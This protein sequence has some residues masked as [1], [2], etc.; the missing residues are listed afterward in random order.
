MP[1]SYEVTTVILGRRRATK[2][3][4]VDPSGIDGQAKSQLA[5]HPE[6]QPSGPDAAADL[7]ADGDS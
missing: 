2:P 3:M 5:A 7:G 1:R 6:N 4:K